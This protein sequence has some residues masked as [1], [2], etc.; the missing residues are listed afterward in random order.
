MGIS[1][2]PLIWLKWK[3]KGIIKQVSLTQ[4]KKQNP[5][6]SINLKPDIKDI[7]NLCKV[8]IQD[9]WGYQI[10]AQ[11]AKSQSGSSS[12]LQSFKSGL[13]GNGGSLHLQ[14]KD[15]AAKFEQ[16]CIREQ[17]PYQAAK[18]WPGTFSILQNPKSGLKGHGD[19]LH[20]QDQDRKPKFRKKVYQRPLTIFKSRSGY[21]F[22][23]RDHQHPPKLQAKT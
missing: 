1:Y 9:Q 11:D 18:S 13:R 2:L 23:V 8:Q 5:A 20:H 16:R 6:S 21:Q 12:I 15:R 14:N 17:W 3:L 10:Q 22:L 19:S 7:D 4:I